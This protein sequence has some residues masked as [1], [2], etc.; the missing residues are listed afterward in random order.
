MLNNKGWGFRQ[1]LIAGAVLFIALIITTFFV[2]RLYS[3]LPNLSSI[4]MES[5]TYEEIENNLD[6][7][8]IKYINEYYDQEITT[9]V[10]VV[11]TDNLLKY[12]I[13]IEKDLINTDNK[14][15]CSGYSLIRKENGELTSKSY[16]KCDN[17]TT[18]GY[19]SWRVN[20][21]NE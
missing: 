8:S 21:N 11:S 14:D 2:I 17:Y 15:L 1:F 12:N 10:I 7:M 19:Q 9:G 18:E 3:N 6:Y 4:I 16:I 20:N 5:F 13:I